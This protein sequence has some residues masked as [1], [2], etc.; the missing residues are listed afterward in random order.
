MADHWRHAARAGRQCSLCGWLDDQ[1]FG[2]AVRDFG[3]LGVCDLTGQNKHPARDL[4]IRAIAPAGT[5]PQDG[6][7]APA[8]GPFSFM[9]WDGRGKAARR[10]P[11]GQGGVAYLLLGI[12]DRCL[13]T[14]L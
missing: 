1:R 9:I 11:P 7:G 8:L 10:A 12:S 5:R 14:P 4:L 3:R 13:P 6:L 2:H